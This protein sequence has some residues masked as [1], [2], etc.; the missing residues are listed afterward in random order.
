MAMMRWVLPILGLICLA[1]AQGDPRPPSLFMTVRP[2][3]SI[4]IKRDPKLPEAG[5]P[6]EI[7]KA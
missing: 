4:T 7:K 1:S 6:T 3:L 2:Q 5:K